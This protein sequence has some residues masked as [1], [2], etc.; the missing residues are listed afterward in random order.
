MRGRVRNSLTN[1]PGAT[2]KPALIEGTASDNLNESVSWKDPLLKWTKDTASG[3]CYLHSVSFFDVNNQVMVKNVIHRDIKPDNC[4]ITDAFGVKVSDFGEARVKE[5]DKTMTMVGTP[6]YVAPEVVRGDRYSASCDVYSFALTILTFALRGRCKV[7][8]T[9][10]RGA[11]RRSA[12]NLPCDELKGDFTQRIFE[13]D[14][15]TSAFNVT[16]TSSFTT[17][18]ARFS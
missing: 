13:S 10:A 2:D 15:D 8:K 12:A 5:D 17:R 3:I 11:K 1:S 4:L 16:N 9:R 18:F 14:A 6:L 7:R